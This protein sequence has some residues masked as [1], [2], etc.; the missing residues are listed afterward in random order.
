MQRHSSNCDTGHIIYIT[1]TIPARIMCVCEW[2]FD[3]SAGA[4]LALTR[5]TLT[6]TLLGKQ[7]RINNNPRLFSQN[8]T[9]TLLAN[10]NGLVR[11]ILSPRFS[12]LWTWMEKKEKKKENKLFFPLRQIPSPQSTIKNID[13]DIYI[14]QRQK[15]ASLTALWM[16]GNLQ[17]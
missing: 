8:H 3:Q 17:H 1:T 12:P 15:C 4:L 7:K 11:G 5:L 2:Y 14:L 10:E 13:F 9:K 16:I 6:N